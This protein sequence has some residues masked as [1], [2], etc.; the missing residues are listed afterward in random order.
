MHG[1]WC[2]WCAVSRATALVATADDPGL[3]SWLA[4]LGSCDA[5]SCAN[6]ETPILNLDIGG[7]TTNLAIGKAGQ[8]LRTG[9]LSIGARHLQVE[10]GGYRIRSLTPQAKATLAH[11]GI[12]RDVGHQLTRGEVDAVLDF[13]LRIIE[14]ESQPEARHA[15]VDIRR[16]YEQVPFHLPRD[17]GSYAVTL[18][19]GVGE[20]VYAHLRGEPWP[21]TTKFGD[22]G[23]DLARRFIETS[24]W[25][26]Q[27]NSKKFVPAGGGWRDGARPVASC[28]RS[29]R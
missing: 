28:H 24:P 14:S 16:G 29:F 13:Y 10:P 7:G 18:S 5:L 11:L 26:N 20:L 19:G 27:L 4:F 3:E 12:A 2:S 6:P 17:V 15:D 21:S 25:A 9:C 23:I 8:V 1:G 22:L